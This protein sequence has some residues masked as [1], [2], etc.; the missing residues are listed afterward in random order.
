MYYTQRALRSASD[1]IKT[2]TNRRRRVADIFPRECILYFVTFCDWSLSIQ[3]GQFVSVCQDREPSLANERQHTWLGTV[4]RIWLQSGNMFKLR[5]SSTWMSERMIIQLTKFEA[6]LVNIS[7]PLPCA[8][9]AFYVQLWQWS[10]VKDFPS[11]SNTDNE[12]WP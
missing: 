11:C 12:K 5:T 2:H 3:K 6:N 9:L 10:W 7:A 8:R 1:S 4:G